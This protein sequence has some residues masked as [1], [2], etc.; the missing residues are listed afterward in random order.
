[1]VTVDA[2]KF[3][4]PRPHLGY[5]VETLMTKYRCEKKISVDTEMTFR[6]RCLN[7][8]LRLLKEL[9]QRLPDS[10]DRLKVISQLSPENALKPLTQSIVQ[11]AKAM[12]RS[13]SAV[14]KID[15]QWRT[16]NLIHWECIKSTTVE[17]WV[18]V[19]Q[20]RNSMAENPFQ[21]LAEFAIECLILPWSNTEI[22]RL[23]SQMK[24]IKT[25]LRNRLSD[26]MLNSIL[27]IRT[28][29]RR[30]GKCCDT[31]EF[32]EEVLRAM[33]KQAQNL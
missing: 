14:S 9:Q 1:M 16:L 4:Y 3:L 2:P 19:L 28:S 29:L 21:E 20:Y 11:L 10:V 15:S 12:G 31:F 27:R 23:F 24:I 25:P 18:E 26:E 13:A 8:I 30:L 17:F 7:F 6:S 22:E 5:D 32:P 33:G